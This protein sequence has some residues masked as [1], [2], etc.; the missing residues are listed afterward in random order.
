M[1]STF[2]GV[3]LHIAYMHKANEALHTYLNIPVAVITKCE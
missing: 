3:F 2:P 1:T